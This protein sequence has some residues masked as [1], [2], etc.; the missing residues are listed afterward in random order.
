MLIVQNLTAGY[1]K[2]PVLKNISF[3][4]TKNQNLSI[5]GAN[6]SGKSTLLKVLAGL[7]P[8][9]GS[10]LL[11]GQEVRNIKRKDMAK[12]LA[13]MGQNTTVYLDYSVDDAVMM[14]RY[15][16]QKKGLFNEVTE[17][18][19][20]VVAESLQVVG[21]LHVKDHAIGTLSGGQL[22]RAFLARTFA[23]APEVILLDEPT[24]HLDLKNQ[25][26]LMSHLS[27]WSKDNGNTL[28]GVLH[29]LNLALRFT[30]TMLLLHE[31]EILSYGKPEEV[32]QEKHLK[33]AFQLDMKDYIEEIYKKWQIIF[34]EKSAFYKKHSLFF[35]QQKHNSVL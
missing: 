18:D 25:I 26:E 7:L 14:G 4:V 6:G 27:R 16:H 32:L 21:L 35:S 13:M 23:Q 12:P 33:K 15:M 5:L 1:G 30:D 34:D 19:R 28:I 17:G 8:Y 2:E 29:D 20:A 9:E 31:G 22:Q 10:V 11:N 3:T 24:N